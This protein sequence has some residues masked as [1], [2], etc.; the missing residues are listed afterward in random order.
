MPAK[1]TLTLGNTS[2]E[3]ALERI[4]PAV[5]EKYL[6]KNTDNYR[7]FNAEYAEQI[8]RDL[9]ADYWDV[10]GDTIKFDEVGDLIDGQHRLSSIMKSQVPAETLVVRGLRRSSTDKSDRGRRRTLADAL[11]RRGVPYATVVAS[12]LSKHW[13]WQSGLFRTYRY[14]ITPSE[15]LA[16]HDTDPELYQRA[17]RIATRIYHNSPV[18]VSQ[19]SLGLAYILC[20][21][22]DAGD[23][24]EFFALLESGEG[25]E[26]NHPIFALRRNL[27]RHAE[28]PN[29]RA[30]DPMLTSVIV[31]TWNLV[32]AGVDEVSQIA[33][34]SSEAI[35]DPQ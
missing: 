10:T 28:D 27:I 19:A 8:A 16:L 17:A 22:M 29:H 30:V 18:K 34:R 9:D 4:T 25:L 24:A 5:A 20:E 23:A 1:A 12:V 26:R 3:V 33:W 31:K 13:Q 21:Q 6:L 11:R 7:R 35:P 15:A 14:R 2:L 32:R